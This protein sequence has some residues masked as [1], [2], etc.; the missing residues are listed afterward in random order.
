[1]RAL[2]NR[3]AFAALAAFSLSV[4]LGHADT[5]AAEADP[6]D[7]PTLLAAA[8]TS[9]AANPI[10]ALRVSELAAATD[11]A[12]SDPMAMA[13][14]L[15]LQG[16][17]LTRL[18][19]P[20]EAQ[21]IVEL[22]IE[23][24]GAETSKL[25]ADLLV[26]RGR[27]ERVLSQEGRALASFQSAYRMFEELGE[28]RSQAIAL[29][30]IGTLYDSAHQYERVI[31]YNEQASEVYSDGGILDL[32]SLNNRANALRE[33]GRY[34]EAVDMLSRAL[35]MAEA[36]GSPLLQVRI[37]TNIAVLEI[38]NNRLA[39]ARAAIEQG[40][41]LSADESAQGWRPFLWGAQ[42]QW[43]AAR[44]DVE[45]SA[46][47]LDQVFDAQ[48]ITATPAPFRDFHETAYKVFRQTGRQTEAL[49]HLEAFKR[50]DDQGRAVA[51]S[52]NLALLNAEFENANKEL[53]IERLRAE[54]LEKDAALSAARARQRR[55]I[56]AALVVAGFGISGFFAFSARAARRTAVAV[57]TLN[58]GLEEKNSA[59]AEA[60]IALEAANNAKLEFLAVTSHEIRTPLNAVIGLSDVVLSDGALKTADRERLDLINSAG[61]HL[62]TIVS[63]I[64]DVSKME[65]G[66][67]D[68]SKKP[69]NIENCVA[70]V[71][72]VWR[73]AAEDKGVSFD[74][75]IPAST[76]MR[77]TDERL[78]RQVVSNLL[79]NAV[80]FTTSGRIGI[81]VE[82]HTND[83]LA[84][85][86]EDTGSG[87]APEKQAEIFEPFR[88]ADGSVQRA[89]SGTGLGLAIVKRIAEAL[90]GT[91]TLT[92]WPDK[93]SR[94]CV[95]IPAD[96]DTDQSAPATSEGQ[97]RDRQGSDD[98][99]FDLS[100]LRILIAEDNPTNAMVLQAY[101]QK[102][103]GSLTVV[104]N[105]ALA[106]EAVETGAFD[107]VLMD[108]QM[109]IMDGV[110]ATK[111]IRAL[112]E[113]L[114]R[115]PIIAVTAD[116]FAGAEEALLAAGMDAY[117][118]KPLDAKELRKVIA[119]TMHR[120]TATTPRAQV[121]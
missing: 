61:K 53:E 5:Q 57:R 81:K 6:K 94:F 104:E 47:A 78:I 37:L 115:I 63:D 11:D 109:P 89:H 105:G 95:E 70:S 117:L 87:I 99:C 98:E 100:T 103:A 96:Q 51:A 43:E 69:L 35:T 27:I 101:L 120:C 31:A 88:Q 93:G 46:E 112:S 3:S 80:K 116:A 32:V 48:D 74:V 77:L 38:R 2:L 7:F 40:F 90:G 86:V 42:A 15:W 75:A 8:K 113:P 23:T 45:A 72:E 30:S 34:E 79:S 22:A 84:I 55:T 13:Q 85:I 71:A 39:E 44:G 41:A 24:V 56:T 4:S 68:V 106:V 60:N 65:S 66:Q 92:S 58:D 29:Q 21:P 76:T 17:A 33:L 82:T 118:S 16:E 52:A 64:L 110:T 102:D 36:S 9:M 28:E 25:A 97:E 111:M 62:L 19:R 121:Q 91:V 50:L 119:E 12:A 18:N 20:T 1:M 10:E 108:K 59:L 54:Q 107:L 83:H 26:A 49:A 73:K 14:A 114:A 67:L